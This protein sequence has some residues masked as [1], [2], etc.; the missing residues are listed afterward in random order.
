MRQLAM[1]FRGILRSQ[2]SEALGGWLKDAHDCGSYAMQRFVR[3]L[4]RDLDAVTN[5][6]TFPWSNGQ[7]EAQISRL[8][9]LKRPMYRRIGVELLR[10]RILPL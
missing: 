9:M 1:R 2:S 5:A 4:Q 3:M 10:A 7:A 8:K 6:L